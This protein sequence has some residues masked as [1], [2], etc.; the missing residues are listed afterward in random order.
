MNKL[1]KW[2]YGFRPRAV[3]SCI[4]AVIF[5]ATALLIVGTEDG[6]RVPEMVIYVVYVCAAVSLTFA[7][8]AVVLAVRGASLKE[9]LHNA[10]QKTGFTSKLMADYSF[11][12]VTATY[13]TLAIDILLALMKAAAGWYFTS[14]W[15]MVL[16]GYYAVLCVA[17]FLLLR[18]N[19]RLRAL[20]DE[21][22]RRRHELRAY[23]LSG[24]LLIAMTAVL[25]G[26]VVLIVRE[27]QG[28]TYHGMLIFA[29]ALYDF[30]CLIRAVVYM[31]GT[32]KMHGPVLVSIK[33]FSFA[34]A[35]VAMLS[36]QTAM[37]ASFGSDTE[38]SIRQ[39][40]NALTGSAVCLILLAIGIC[41]V[42]G[43]NKR[44]R[45]M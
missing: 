33:T 3:P 13:G 10:A 34:S 39:L 11:R 19:R 1:R 31:V 4:A 30:Y 45:R 38:L 22:E 44:L 35:L 24:T 12:M 23:R 42:I 15:L 28:F 8:W 21:R 41:M 32:R 17:R 6:R 25:Q 20:T 7:V 26:V 27:G 5:S 9:R 29:V 2:I 36:L 40:M 14:A 37:F 16:A 18:S 43:A